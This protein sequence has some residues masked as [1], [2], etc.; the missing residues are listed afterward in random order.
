MR[1]TVLLYLIPA[2]LVASSW[3]RLEEEPVGGQAFW[4]A[5]LALAPALVRRLWLR[6]AAFAAAS[7]LA[8]HSAFGLWA[9]DA[10]PFDGRHDFFGPLLERFGRGILAFYDVLLPFDP[11]KHAAMH[12]VLL[13]AVFGFCLAVALAVAGRR[14]LA[15]AASLVVG[16]GWPLTILPA[17]GDL[18]RGSFVLA[19]VLLLLVGLRTQGG[20]RLGQSVAAGGGIVLLALAASTQPAIAKGEFLHDWRSW[21]FYSKPEK[22]VGVAYV[23]NSHYRGIRFP[24]KKTTVLRV[25]GPSSSLYWR[26]T[27]L[28][29]FN[30]YGWVEDPT[31]VIVDTVGGRDDL[32]GDSLLPRRARS[33]GWIEQEV[34][35]AALRDNHL[36]GASVPVAFDPGDLRPV[37]YAAGGIAFASRDLSSGERYS[38]WSF[39][40][41]PT[42]AQL[43]RSKAVYPPPISVEGQYLTVARAVPLPPFGTPQRHLSVTAIFRSLRYDERIAPYERL[44]AKAREIVGEPRSP[45][46]AVVALESWFRSGGGFRYDERPPLLQDVPPLV[47]FV[48]ETKRGYCQYY[49]G[50][51]ALMLRYLGIPARVAAGFTSGKYDA[52]SRTWTVTDHNAHTWVEV[53]FRGYGWLPFDPTPARG[54]LSAPYTASSPSFDASGAVQALGGSAAAALRAVRLS[55]ERRGSGNAPGEFGRFGERDPLG[56]GTPGRSPGRDRESLLVLIAL[57]ACGLGASIALAKLFVRRGR[58]LTRD[59]RRLAGA[60]RREVVEFLVDQRI[61]VA[62]SLTLAELG[63]EIEREFVVDADPFVGALARARFGPSGEAGDAIRCARRELRLLRRELR[64]QLGLPSRVRGALRLRSLT[65]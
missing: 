45:Y 31:F 22:P 23:W 8:V 63:R 42:P 65:V 41:K 60:C 62:S 15:A 44:Y 29:T 6:L 55:L 51:M 17:E 56:A 1:K 64:R 3:L 39:A 21:D 37:A 40:A 9:L 26:A 4:M 54:R 34:T 28:D 35:V 33:S 27:T 12:G 46:A 47:A 13:L 50:A 53:W 18:A 59:P 20:R 58:Y 49:A 52:K 10:R 2:W 38:V 5:V 25:K 48:T 30:G 36:V 57:L 11:R 24:Q 14:P 7:V 61:A 16:A 19:T 43:A 32:S